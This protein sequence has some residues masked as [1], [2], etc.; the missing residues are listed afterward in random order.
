MPIHDNTQYL[1]N[2][3]GV[4]LSSYLGNIVKKYNIENIK[5]PYIMIVGFAFFLLFCKCYIYNVYFYN[6]PAS[7]IVGTRT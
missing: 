7:H 4:V 5:Y 1:V 2:S 6:I 3:K